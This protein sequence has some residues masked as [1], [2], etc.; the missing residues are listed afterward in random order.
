VQAKLL[1]DVLPLVRFPT[2]S[3]ADF[4]AFAKL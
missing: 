3:A 2:M 4:S 1:A